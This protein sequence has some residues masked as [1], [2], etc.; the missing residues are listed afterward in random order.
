VYRNLEEY[1]ETLCDLPLSEIYKIYEENET[2]RQ[3]KAFYPLILV[4]TYLK[5]L[6][7]AWTPKDFQ[8]PTPH[9]KK[10]LIFLLWSL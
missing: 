6:D 8:R 9:T 1:E 2:E 4:C 3:G 7:R 5:S 10:I